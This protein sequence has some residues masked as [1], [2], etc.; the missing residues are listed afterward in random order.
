MS[1]MT[2]QIE[3]INVL[4]EKVIINPIDYDIALILAKIRVSQHIVLDEIMNLLRVYAD[5]TNED[6]KATIDNLKKS[7]D[8]I[9]EIDKDIRTKNN[10]WYCGVDNLEDTDKEN[11]D[12][13]KMVSK[14]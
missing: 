5:N 3:V 10:Y 2:K 1:K 14:K 9:E 7:Y 12:L 4:N 6:L 11:Y 13:V 8:T